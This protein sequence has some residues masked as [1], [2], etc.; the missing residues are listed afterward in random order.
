[1]RI[2][3][4]TGLIAALVW[5]VIKLLFFFNGWNTQD[6]LPVVIMINILGLLLAIAVGLYL[7]KKRDTEGSNTL[8]DI[9]NAMTAG[10]PYA[11]VVSMFLYFYYE[12]IDPEFNQRLIAEREMFYLQSMDTPEE[13]Q[14]IRA[15]NKDFE[16]MTKD[17]IYEKLSEGSRVFY[18]GKFVATVGLLAMLVLSTLYSIL[19]TVIY[20]RIMFR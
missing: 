10:V 14:E 20:R 18:S 4:K 15:S 6:T 7:Q 13:L 12:K 2:T 16:V 17:E 1:M 19:I 5:I 3:L 11:V 8:R 9:K